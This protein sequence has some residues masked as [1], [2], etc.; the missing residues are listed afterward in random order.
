[1]FYI[2]HCGWLRQSRTTAAQTEEIP[3]MEPHIGVEDTDITS[4]RPILHLYVQSTSCLHSMILA[5]L[6]I[7]Y[8]QSVNGPVLVAT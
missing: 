4:S 3:V 2:E 8:N 1:M 5:A 7:I 6:S